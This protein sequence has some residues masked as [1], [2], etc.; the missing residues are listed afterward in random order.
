M[1]EAGQ[2]IGGDAFHGAGAMLRPRNADSQAGIADLH[3]SLLFSKFFG[4][5][6]LGPSRMAVS[7]SDIGYQKMTANKVGN[8]DDDH[9]Q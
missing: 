4:F 6:P 8:V 9:P 2:N 1:D 5:L 3:K 7:L